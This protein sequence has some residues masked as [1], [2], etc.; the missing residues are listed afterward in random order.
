LGWWWVV[1]GI[2]VRLD[3]GRPKERYSGV[4]PT[5]EAHFVLPYKNPLPGSKVPDPQSLAEACGVS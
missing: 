1:K 2:V 4:E 5:K 3:Y